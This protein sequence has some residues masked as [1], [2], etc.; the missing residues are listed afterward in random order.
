MNPYSLSHLSDAVLLRDLATHSARE[1]EATALLLAH[2]AEVEARELYLSEGF[3]SMADYCVHRLHRSEQAAFKRIRAARAARDFP[4]IFSAVA[5]GRLHLSAVILLAPRLTAENAHE[6]LAAAA[7]KT[8]PEIERLLAERFPRRAVPSPVAAVLDQLSL[9]R[10]EATDTELSSRRVESCASP[11]EVPVA[12]RC[13]AQ[14][15]MR[16][17]D[18]LSRFKALAGHRVPSGDLTELLEYALDLGIAVLEKRKF[19]ATSKPRPARRSKPGSRTIPS[20]VKRLVRER[21]GEQCAFVS[22]TGQRCT[23]RGRLEFDHILEVARGGTSTV[24]N[25]RLLCRA[26]NQ[27]LAERTYGAGFMDRKREESRR[28]TA[29][30]KAAKEH[31]RAAAEKARAA[32]AE[33]RSRASE[34][35]RAK[36]EEVIPYLR[37]LKFTADEARRAAAHCEAIPD[38]P[39]E[40]RVRLALRSTPLRGTFHA[41][42]SAAQCPA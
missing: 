8:M 31:T 5:E 10:V 14:S 35:A 24:D 16:M 26:H 19:A 29:E 3:P 18:K 27:Y 4:A 36:A 25:V 7:H 38:A 39:L 21:D 1:C 32:E 37:A 17:K 9:R 11:A 6:L 42:P 22:D 15:A 30:A 23:A 33:A 13:D 34:Q 20:D 40:E 2:V 12:P 41:A 28:K